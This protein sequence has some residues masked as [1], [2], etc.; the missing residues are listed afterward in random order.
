MSTKEEKPT[1]AGVNVKT[2]KRN[3]VVPADPGSFATAIVQIF[4][5]AS[6][7]VSVEKDLEAGV[8]VLDSA[9]LDFSRYADTLFEVLFAGG[10]LATGGNLADEQKDKLATNVLNTEATTE[11]LLPYIK[12]FQSLI[13]R[14]PFL[15]K[16]LEA[17]LNKFILSLEFY[18]EEGRK[19]IA[20]ASAMVFSYKLGALPENVL[21]TL[22]ND[23]LVA[24]GS[25][26]HFMTT[27]FQTYLAKENLDDLVTLLTKARVVDRLLEF[28]PP[29]K[30]SMEDFSKHFSDAG[31]QPLVEWNTRRELDTKVAELQDGLSKM[32]QEDPP[33]T[34][35]EITSYI[36]TRKTEQGLPDSDVVRVLIVCIMKSINLTG[37]NQMQIMQTVIAKIK[38][39]HKVLQAFVTNA[40]L[41]LTVLTTLQVL[42][43][44]D[45][46][47]LK[48]YKDIVKLL[49]NAD[50][51]GEDTISHWYKKG[52]HPKGRNVFLKDMEPFIKWLE[53]AEEEEDEEEE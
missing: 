13:R 12:V 40:K 38:A 3:I 4:Q 15:V 11:A 33:H 19:K 51:V 53:E 43:Y 41:E 9:D 7:G 16:G 24:K 6:D 35:A 23:R 32:M 10:R 21:Q 48:L 17:T 39:Y 1:L 22:L 46:R 20:M 27:F 45:N 37:K 28:M 34:A 2:R 36:K 14:R 30:R 29:S 50:V 49:Y 31:L 8:K 44:E 47:L 52:S 5:D 18:D 26:M 42:C 25:V